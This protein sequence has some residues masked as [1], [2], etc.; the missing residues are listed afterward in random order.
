M[1]LLLF[2]SY[3]GTF[4]QK[5]SQKHELISK[6]GLSIDFGIFL[7]QRYILSVIEKKYERST[8]CFKA[9]EKIVSDFALRFCPVTPRH[10]PGERDVVLQSDVLA[11]SPISSS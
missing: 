9:L 2:M 3:G 10:L 8:E 11:P 5:R 4:F 7:S 1:V 6:M